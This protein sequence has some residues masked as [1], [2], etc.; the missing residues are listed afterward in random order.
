VDE[1]GLKGSWDF[2]PTP[3]L[4]INHIEE[5][6]TENQAFFLKAISP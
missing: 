1:T 4:V 5:K 6:P 3:V 2:D